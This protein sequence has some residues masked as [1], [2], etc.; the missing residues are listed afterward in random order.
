MSSTNYNGSF[1]MIMNICEAFWSINNTGYTSF[2]IVT[3]NRNQPI[4]K[5]ATVNKKIE[6]Q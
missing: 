3:N 5:R 2:Y 6:K 4:R 1:S